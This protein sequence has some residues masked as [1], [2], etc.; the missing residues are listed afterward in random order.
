MWLARHERLLCN[1]ERRRRHLTSDGNCP[2]C[3]DVDESVEHVL[4]LCPKA[5]EIWK[6][7]LGD[8]IMQRMENLDF[9]KWMDCN[10]R[11][12]GGGRHGEEW[13]NVFIIT[14]WWIWKWRNDLV[15][16]DEE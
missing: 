5:K 6:Q 15:F 16:K 2:V 14:A 10:L 3:H 9:R 4:R 1:H 12:K 11:G 7:L 13:P 8:R